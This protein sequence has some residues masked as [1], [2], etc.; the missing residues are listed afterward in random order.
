MPLGKIGPD[1]V[2]DGLHIFRGKR[3]LVTGSTGFKGSWLCE[4]LLSLGAEVSGFALAPEPDAL[5]FDQLRLRDRIDQH[6]G[7]IRDF[8]AVKFVF[9]KTKPEV[10]LHLAAQALVRESYKDPKYTFDTNVSGGVNL[11]EAVR[12]STCVKALVFVTT[13]KCYKNKEWEWGYREVDELGGHDPYSAS[14]A[15][16]E[17]VFMGYQKSYFLE[18]ENFGA[19]TARAGNVIGGGDWSKDRIVPDCLRALMGGKDILV[20]NPVSTRPWQHVLDPLSGYLEIAKHILEGNVDAQGAWNFGSN[21][22]NVR[23]VRELA[24]KLVSVWGHGNICENVDPKAPHEAG[25]LTLTSE[26]AKS[27]LGWQGRWGF[28]QAVEQT[29]RW[30]KR[31]HAGEDPIKA[32]ISDIEFYQNHS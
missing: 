22:E 17:L 18:R 5:L 20:R 11:L 23:S 32:T 1:I 29:A 30:H 2:S 10:V 27:H 4:W 3:V 28:D 19:A 25:L 12:Q 13:D 14:K 15:A 9:E 31:V 24:D 16:A 8:E 7:D 26:K 21:P 6:D